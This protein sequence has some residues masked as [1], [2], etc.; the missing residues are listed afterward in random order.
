MEPAAERRPGGAQHIP[1]PRAW[2]PGGA[3]PWSDVAAGARLLTTAAIVQLVRGRRPQRLAP[4][5]ST[6][7]NSAVLVLLHQGDEGPELLFTRR[8]MH[9]RS[10]RG[11]ISFPGGRMDAGETPA[12]TALR[13]AWE[14]VALDPAL[15]TVHGELDHMSTVASQSYIVPVVASVAERPALRPHVA[16]VDRIMWVSLAD[17]QRP[18]TYREERWGTPPLDRPIHF[19]E[20]DDETVWGATARMVHQ[21]LRL[22]HG[23]DEPEPQD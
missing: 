12:Q 6:A 22:A 20:L 17:L 15:V 7:R 13:E 9:M 1:R 10:H 16:E 19:F 3:A 2:R 11:E 4:P 5:F 21:L 8:P 18:G 23:V 14:E